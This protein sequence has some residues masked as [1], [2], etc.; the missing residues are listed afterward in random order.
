MS[1]NKTITKAGK[2]ATFGWGVFGREGQP[3]GRGMMK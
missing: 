2:A 3:R 1:K